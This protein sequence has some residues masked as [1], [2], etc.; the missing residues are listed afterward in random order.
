MES[1]NNVLM[2]TYTPEA[3]PAQSEQNNKEEQ[4]DESKCWKKM[5]LK[6][7]A[8]FTGGCG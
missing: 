1:M 2:D 3:P 7:E 4:Q 8:R 6:S 5:L